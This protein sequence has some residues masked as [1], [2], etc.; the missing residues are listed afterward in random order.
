MTPADLSQAKK[1][2][3]PAKYI[4][5]GLLAGI[6]LGYAIA[7][8]RHLADRRIHTTDDISRLLRPSGSFARIFAMP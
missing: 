3:S 4:I 7:L 6:I 8:I 1:A 5:A 2:P